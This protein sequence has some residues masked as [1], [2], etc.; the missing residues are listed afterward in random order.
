M[1][2]KPHPNGGGLVEDTAYVAETAYLGKY[3]VV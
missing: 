3:A 2:F 1:A